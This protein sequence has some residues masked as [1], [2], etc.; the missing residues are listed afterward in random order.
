ME[1]SSLWKKLPI[2]IIKPVRQHTGFRILSSRVS[3]RGFHISGLREFEIGDS[4][5][6]ISRK[7]YV[8][9]GKEII[10]ERH[11][12]QNA[13]ILFLF[14]VSAS[15]LVGS[16]RRKIDAAF[17]LLRHFGS[18][19]LWQGNKIQVL[20]FSSR[21]E[22]ESDIIVTYAAFEQLLE[23]LVALVPES[24]H[25]DHSEAV[26]RA[27]MISEKR[28]APADLVCI[29]SD[30]LFPYSNEIFYHDIN[31]LHDK[32]DVIGLL[33]NDPAE[34]ALPRPPGCL[35]VRDIET[36]EFYWL[37]EIRASD[38]LHEFDKQDFDA[39]LLSTSQDD[40]QWYD[41]LDDFFTLRKEARQK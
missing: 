35:K 26:D 9:T 40:Q 33:I 36:G 38:I 22:L 3:D 7:H 12:E 25:T 21:I 37:S 30:L 14:D 5:R 15:M 18:A 19:C 24:S 41:V 32:T 11:P 17:D 10:I 13:L 28:N 20:A 23:E 2:T 6:S 39:C 29:V 34:E 1:I 8:R 27:I 31:V 16:I 4:F